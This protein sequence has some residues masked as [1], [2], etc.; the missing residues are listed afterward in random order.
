MRLLFCVLLPLA[1]AGPTIVLDRAMP[2]PDGAL[3]ERALLAANA[4]AAVEFA[5][6]YLDDRGLFRCLERWGGNDGPDDVMENF[7]NWTLAYALGAA[8]SILHCFE[9]AWEGHLIP[10][11]RARAPSVEMARAG[12]RRPPGNRD[13]ALRASADAGV[14]LGLAGALLG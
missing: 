8:E 9:K 3:A 10:Y 5:Q 7:H 2:P 12:R 14:S 4:E 6:K 13:A 1:A 11:T